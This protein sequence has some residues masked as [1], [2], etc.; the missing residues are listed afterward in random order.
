MGTTI[1]ALLPL[2]NQTT[3][4]PTNSPAHLQVARASL[5]SREYYRSIGNPINDGAVYFSFLLNVAVNPTYSD[6]FLGTMI[7]AGASNAPVATDPLSIHAGKVDTTHFN[8]G[9]QS[10]GGAVSWTTTSLALNT[11]YLVVLQYN[12]GA[13]QTCQLFIN[14]IPGSA[15]PAASATTSKGATGDP[16]NI[17]TILFYEAYNNVPALTSGTY[18]YDVMR[19]DTNW[20]NV[21]PAVLVATKLAISPPPQIL[22]ESQNSSLITV[23]LENQFDNPFTNASATVVN[24]SSSS[25]GGTFLS[26]LDGVTSINNVT[27]AAGTS[28]ATF[29]YTDNIP[30]N[31]TITAASGS[32]ISASQTETVSAQFTSID[33]FDVTTSVASTNAG[34]NFTITVQAKDASNNPISGNSVDGA[35]VIVNSPGALF[36]DTDGVFIGALTNGT[37]TFSAYDNRAETVTITATYATATGSRPNFVIT[38]GEP[39]QVLVET[40]AD[41]T[42][43]VVPQQVVPHGTALT[44]FAIRRDAFGNFYDNVAAD[45]WLLTNITGGVAS[46]DLIT[47]GDGKSAVFTGNNSGAA[48]IHASS[49]LLSATD[50]GTITVPSLAVATQVR[51]ETA[52]DGTGVVVPGQTINKGTAFTAYAIRRDA[53]GNFVDNVAAD[54]WALVI[55]SGGVVGSDLAVAPDRK[56]AV[57]TANST[58]TAKIHA[59]S[60]FLSTIDSG[61]L[62]VPTTGGNIVTA[63]G[64]QLAN[65]LSSFMVDTYWAGG[66]SVNLLTGATNGTSPNMTTGTATHCSAF[67]AAVAEMLGI[68]VLRPP[69]HSDVSLANAQYLW[70]KTNNQGWFSLQSSFTV[71][72]ANWQVAALAA[73][74]AANTG[75]LVVASYYNPS[76]AGHFAFIRP[77]TKPDSDVTNVAIGPQECQSGGINSS[78]TNISAGFASPSHWP[79]NILYW[80]HTVQ[81]PLNPTTVNPILAT[82]AAS[83]NILSFSAKT[84]VGRKYTLQ[85]STNAINWANVYSFT[86]PNTSSAF[87]Y[88]NQITG[89]NGTSK[90]GFYRLK[91]W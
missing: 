69:Q 13:G 81:Y 85:F 45:S 3:A 7:A 82:K 2:P 34:Q 40:A 16:T 75:A 10:Q 36:T 63:E 90:D 20:A 83:N 78:S 70:F 22:V 55:L 30:G 47:S 91:D 52:A 79:S 19:I 21:T 80:G 54:S 84:I 49:G 5:N 62:T 38:A 89:T 18:N 60:V 26:G 72:M 74:H 35:L 56:S 86:N 33:H 65:Y 68:Y 17:G 67:G 11:D 77:S 53:S 8:L 29:Y 42:G 24:L 12:F 73:Q 64:Q 57:F 4:L 44:V 87:Y 39:T 1:P 41:G 31:P 25:S 43:S 46:G 58:G 50:S 48:A 27:I 71:P 23:T 28:T 61:T 76:G 32:L 6:E 14:P 9:I 66:Y 88:T 15:Q 59:T 37:F 51:V